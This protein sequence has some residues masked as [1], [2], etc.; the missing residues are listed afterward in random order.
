MPQWINISSLS[1]DYTE[2][3]VMMMVYHVWKTAC[4]QEHSLKACLIN[5]TNKFPLILTKS[6][7]L[8]FVTVKNNW[9]SDRSDVRSLFYLSPS[10]LLHPS[11]LISW[12]LPIFLCFIC[13]ALFSS[14]SPQSTSSSPAPLI[15]RAL[16][17][18]FPPPPVSLITLPLIPEETVNSGF[19][20]MQD[21]KERT[22]L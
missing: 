21:G 13:F 1:A 19:T 9:G 22:G 2:I 3:K 12:P 16:P 18:I 5:Y 15:F 8:Q 7:S 20:V 4:K 10:L 17:R 11:S 6:T 14:S